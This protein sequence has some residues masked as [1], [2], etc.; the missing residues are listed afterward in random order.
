MILHKGDYS[1]QVTFSGEEAIDAGGLRKVC[2][3]AYYPCLDTSYACC[4]VHSLCLLLFQV[5]FVGEEAVDE[6]GVSK[7]GL[8]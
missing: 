5:V 3:T 1:L 2:T 7:V 6:G 4:A 8:Y